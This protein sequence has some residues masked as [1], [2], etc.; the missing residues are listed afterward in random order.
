MN[1]PRAALAY[2]KKEKKKENEDF[3]ALSR[4]FHV[5]SMFNINTAKRD[6]I[7]PVTG[8]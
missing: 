1:C 3:Q 5:Y 2:K 7:Y 6:N 8:V 4:N